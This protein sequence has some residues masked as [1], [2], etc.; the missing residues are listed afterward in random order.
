MRTSERQCG[1]RPSVEREGTIHV[2]EVKSV[3]NTNEEKQLRLGLG[4]V[5]RYR[6]L[7][8]V[9]GYRAVAVLVADGGAPAESWQALC[10]QL[11]VV[12]TWPAPSTGSSGPV[13]TPTDKFERPRRQT[14]ITLCRTRG[15]PGPCRTLRS[16]AIC[17]ARRRDC[18]AIHGRSGRNSPTFV[19]AIA[20]TPVV[21]RP[22]NTLRSGCQQGTDSKALVANIE[23]GPCRGRATRSGDGPNKSATND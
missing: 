14:K 12:L 15:R 22:N 19:P 7:L 8:A 16:L 10:D 1:R 11:G 6:Q 9:A 5:L 23:A 20:T 18:T 4:Q 13:P 2:A 3:T 21:R 17:G